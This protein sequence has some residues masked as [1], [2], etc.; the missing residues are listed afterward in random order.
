MATAAAR[1]SAPLTGPGSR[2][3]FVVSESIHL[4]ARLWVGTQIGLEFKHRQLF[5]FNYS[6]FMVISYPS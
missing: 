3:D 5:L 4:H 2:A 6:C 1:D